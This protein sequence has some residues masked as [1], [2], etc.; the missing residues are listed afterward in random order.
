MEATLVNV[1]KKIFFNV[2]AER[3]I[4]VDLYVAV[5][6]LYDKNIQ[7]KIIFHISREYV[8]STGVSWSNLLV[9]NSMF[10]CWRTWEL[11]GTDT[12]VPYC[13]SVQECIK[14]SL[15]FYTNKIISITL[16]EP[17]A[18]RISAPILREKSSNSVVYNN[19]YNNDGV[20]NSIAYYS[21]LDVLHIKHRI[22]LFRWL[23]W[24]AWWYPEELKPSDGDQR[25]FSPDH[26]FLP[27]SRVITSAI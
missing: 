24:S 7:F 27:N 12:V 1:Q 15:M 2:R 6:E 10:I 21:T 5:T 8:Q 14:S 19:N 23:W 18:P 13:L 26:R 22:H 4:Y 9:F 11:D 20:S 3:L 16:T 17:N 25:F